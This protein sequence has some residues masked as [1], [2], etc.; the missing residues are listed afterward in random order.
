MDEVFKELNAIGCK[1]TAAGSRVTCAPAPETS[2]HDY[3]VYADGDDGVLSQVVAILSMA[4]F[5]WEGNSKHYQHCGDEG[6]MSWRKDQ[7]NL[8]VTKNP[9]FARRHKLATQVCKEL[10][11]MNKPDRIRLFQAILYEAI[12]DADGRFVPFEK[13]AAA[14]L[15]F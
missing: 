15:Q 11:L 6:F 8:I 12:E 7:L 1:I 2:D 9:G 13:P 10:N 14:E 3:L 5:V 4:G